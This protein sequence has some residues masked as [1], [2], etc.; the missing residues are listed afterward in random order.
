MSE[1]HPTS[2]PPEDQIAVYLNRLRAGF[3]GTNQL[4]TMQ[5]RPTI[6]E[7]NPNHVVNVEPLLAIDA[8]GVTRSC[9]P[10]TGIALEPGEIPQSIVMDEGLRRGYEYMRQY[11]S[12]IRLR[13]LLGAHG[14]ANDLNPDETGFDLRAEAQRIAQV[15][16]VLYVE[17][18]VTQQSQDRIRSTLQRAADMDQGN[19]ELGRLILR[20]LMDDTA[21]RTASPPSFIDGIS[22]K[23]MGTGVTVEPIDFTVGGDRQADQILTALTREGE[24][25]CKAMADRTT[26]DRT[27]YEYARR[28]LFTTD[29][30]RDIYL[31]CRIG[32][33]LA[34]RFGP[35][36]ETGID[37]AWY[38]GMGHE[39]IG[40][41]LT[42]E[43]DVQVEFVGE[44]RHT[45]ERFMYYVRC[46]GRGRLTPEDLDHL[47][48]L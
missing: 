20:M 46:L 21:A 15:G 17:S 35:P 2:R 43:T 4:P 12:R 29:S 42:N 32:L 47:W 1:E 48:E 40:R 22:E 26:A 14:S 19:V 5:V 33:D 13:L 25:A 11:G 34:E 23:I 8:L 10:V 3:S 31:P 9:D 45:T 37:V 38:L 24:R 28:V 27:T 44:S 16:G 36:P 41:R 18:A 6:P 39:N 30:Y 7:A